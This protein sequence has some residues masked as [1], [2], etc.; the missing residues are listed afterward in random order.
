M[1]LDRLGAVNAKTAIQLGSCV[2]AFMRSRPGA[3]YVAIRPDGRRRLN[4]AAGGTADD[5]VELTGAG[6]ENIRDGKRERRPFSASILSRPGWA[7]VTTIVC[8]AGGY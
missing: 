8:L 3:G 7:C 6:R 1:T 5:R 2:L 4:A